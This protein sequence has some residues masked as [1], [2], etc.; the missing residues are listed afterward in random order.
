M[1]SSQELLAGEYVSKIVRFLDFVV[2]LFV[3]DLVV[4]KIASRLLVYYMMYWM[5]VSFLMVENMQLM[6]YGLRM[7]NTV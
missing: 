5:V 2:E 7:R 3:I 4:Q 6:D 1:D